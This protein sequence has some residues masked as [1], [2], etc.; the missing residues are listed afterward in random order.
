MLFSKKYN[1]SDRIPENLIDEIGNEIDCMFMAVQLETAKPY[2]LSKA[3]SFHHVQANGRKSVTVRPEPLS[4]TVAVAGPDVKVTDPKGKVIEDTRAERIHRKEGFATLAFKYG[5]KDKTALSVLRSFRASINDPGNSLI[6]LYE[7]ED[8]LK[9]EFC[10]RDR[11]L[12]ALNMSGA[13]WDRLHKL[14]N[15]E[16]LKEGRH[17]GSFVGE[18]R[19]VTKE[20]LEGARKIAQEMIHKYLRYLQQGRK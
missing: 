17:R 6:H 1:K 7:I 3:Y 5:S 2:K 15:D 16:P 12:T 10:N 11:V 18:L 8:A 9:K 19:N 4:V 14:A 20:E 13:K